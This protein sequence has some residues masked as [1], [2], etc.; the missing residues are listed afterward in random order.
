MGAARLNVPAI[1]VSGNPMLPGKLKGK[2][3]DL[4]HSAFE[5]VDSYAEGNLSYDDLNKIEQHSCPTCGSCAGLF[6]ANSM[7]SLI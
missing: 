1:Y 4:V 7:N 6:T 3:I 5:A 2:K